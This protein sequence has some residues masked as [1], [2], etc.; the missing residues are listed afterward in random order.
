MVFLTLDLKGKE[1]GRRK[2][3]GVGLFNNKLRKKKKKITMQK[4]HINSKKKNGLKK[5]DIV[6]SIGAHKTVKIP[7]KGLKL[8]ACLPLLF[9][10]VQVIKQY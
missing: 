8:I 10:F 6:L 9:C 4:I 5:D 1:S 2:K 3:K 7:R